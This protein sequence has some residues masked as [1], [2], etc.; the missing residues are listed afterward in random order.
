MNHVTGYFKRS[1]GGGEIAWAKRHFVQIK[2]LREV[3]ILSDEIKLRLKRMGIEPESK[4]SGWTDVEKALVLKVRKNYDYK[5]SKPDCE[6]LEIFFF[7]FS[8]CFGGCI[9]SKLFF[10]RCKGKGNNGKRVG[11]NFMREKSFQHG[12]FE[13]LSNRTTSPYIFR[14]N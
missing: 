10:S 1:Q 12:L 6:T 5:N 3:K 8:V 4:F 11:E 13:K 14:F 2:T 9:L 7:F